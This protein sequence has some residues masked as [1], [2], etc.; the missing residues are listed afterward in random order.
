MLRC[1]IGILLHRVPSL[2]VFAIPRLFRHPPPDPGP[3]RSRCPRTDVNIRWEAAQD[4]V[5]ETKFPRSE[6]ARLLSQSL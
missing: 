5:A 1:I 3:T 4:Q 6:E 2:Q